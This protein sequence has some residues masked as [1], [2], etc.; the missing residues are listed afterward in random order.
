MPRYQAS[1]RLRT[2]ERGSTPPRNTPWRGPWRRESGWRSPWS[3][4][5]ENPLWRSPRRSR[6]GVVSGF[7]RSTLFLSKFELALTPLSLCRA[8][9]LNL[10]QP[11]HVSGI[12]SSRTGRVSASIQD[13][14]KQ[15]ARR[16][17]VAHYPMTAWDLRHDTLTLG[18]NAAIPGETTCQHKAPTLR[19]NLTHR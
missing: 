1:K 14:A 15:G 5:Y 3:N 17:G 6:P 7:L 9:H 10:H 2:S 8:Q 18:A 13:E 16:Q 19:P 11:Q 12:M 4:L